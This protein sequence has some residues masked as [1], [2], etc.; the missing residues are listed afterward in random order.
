MIE[1]IEIRPENSGDE[2]A[3]HDVTAM[4]FKPKAYSD[5][6]E[7]QLTYDL[8]KSGDMTLSLVA[9]KAGEI[10][11]NVMFSPVTIANEHSNWFGLGPVSVHPDFQGLGVSSQ[12]IN[13]G[14]A[15]LKSEG[16]KGCALVGD[17]KYYSR[18]GFKND[19]SLSYGDTP[20]HN[21]M[22]LSFDDAVTKGELKFCTAFGE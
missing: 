5:G 9:T 12:L 21:V 13:Q 2:Q 8:R 17:P 1:D 6:T 22:R 10:I 3:I 20:A 14:L 7:A 15:Q 18:F 19:G 4:A 11:G 16:A